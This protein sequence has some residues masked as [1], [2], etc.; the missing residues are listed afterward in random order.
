M[1]VLRT[2]V[3]V[4]TLMAFFGT[5][6]AAAVGYERLEVNNTAQK[7]TAAKAAPSKDL[8]KALREASFIDK[9]PALIDQAVFFV[10]DILGQFGITKPK[11]P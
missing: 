7:Q 5:G 1:R 10:K 11:A 8:G 4:A 6:I 2:S 9:C 3:I